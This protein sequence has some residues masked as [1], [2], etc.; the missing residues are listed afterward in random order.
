MTQ[1]DRVE[2]PT[3]AAA[4]EAAGIRTETEASA[5]RVTR[6]VDALR[7]AEAQLARRR[8]GDCGP[9]QT[10][11]EALRLVAD[12]ADRGDPLTPSQVAQRIGVSNSAMTPVLKRLVDAGLIAFRKSSTDAR[13]KTI[14][15]TDRTDPDTV[16]PLA[17]RIRAIADDLPPATA[18]DVAVFLEQVR[19]S[20]DA[21]CSPDD[22][23][24]R[25]RER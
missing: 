20:V 19:R 4:D 2:A 11:R 12:A 14:V 24:A 18:H 21:E 22:P 13:S 10:S 7:I 23:G 15:P 6:G 25:P 3:G 1:A 5:A 17:A 9:S 8:Q 16:D